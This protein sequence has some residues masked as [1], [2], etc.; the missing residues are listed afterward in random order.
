MARRK[1]KKRSRAEE[2]EPR[3][4]I[5]DRVARRNRMRGSGIRGIDFFKKPEIGESKEVVVLIDTE[6]VDDDGQ[7]YDMHEKMVHW[8]GP[9]GR[10]KPIDCTMAELGECDEC[11]KGDTPKAQ[12]YFKLYDVD[13]EK[14]VAWN[15]S[16]AT[17]E[18]FMD[19]DEDHALHESVCRVKRLRNRYQ[20]TYID[21]VDDFFDDD[22]V[23]WDVMDESEDADKAMR[24]YFENDD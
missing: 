16:D 21:D 22:D 17:M 8:I 9:K 23:Y 24:D 20:V 2:D 7:E 13:E 12:I 14:I 1:R 4:S 6:S 10:G 15:V 5:R 11:E 3:G 19:V 18:N